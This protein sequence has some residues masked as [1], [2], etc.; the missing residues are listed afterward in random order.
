M[1]NYSNT[2]PEKDFEDADG[3]LAELNSLSSKIDSCETE[4]EL[5]QLT[6]RIQEISNQIFGELENYNLLQNEITELNQEL[7][8]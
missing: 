5:V 2:N 6:D 1:I 7:N 4:E 8:K 3:L